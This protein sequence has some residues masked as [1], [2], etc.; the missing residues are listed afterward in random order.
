MGDR[1]LASQYGAQFHYLI[2]QN[3]D[4]ERLKLIWHNLDDH[5][6]RFRLMSDQISGRL[7][8]S[9]GEHR[10]VLE[11][12]E[13]RDPDLAEA[14]LKEHLHSVIAEMSAE[15]QAGAQSDGEERV[16]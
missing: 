8:K 1:S 12:L 14:R 2:L 11:A 4:N 16:L 5:T 13:Q 6:Q 10:R 7:E 9:L 15:Q 3:A